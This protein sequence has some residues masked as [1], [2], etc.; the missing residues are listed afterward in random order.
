M[1]DPT[2]SDVEALS[3]T[4]WKQLADTKKQALLD[5]AIEETD[6]L[7]SDRQARMPT[8]D[9]SRSIFIKNLA[10]HKW[11]LAEGGESQSESNGG[12]SVSYNTVTGDAIES[13][14]QTRYG[15]T[16]LDHVR[17]RQ[18]LGIARTRY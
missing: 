3:S 4:G 8:L 14:Q 15:R 12:G 6:S 9:G 2:V 7:Y 17:D 18:G 11:E 13:L 5:D 1:A 10:A 16:A